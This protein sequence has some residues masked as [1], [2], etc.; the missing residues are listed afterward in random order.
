MFPR[1][2]RR[3]HLPGKT[4][5]TNS[6]KNYK[7]KFLEKL[8]VQIP[9]KTASTNSWKNYMYK[10]LEWNSPQVLLAFLFA[11]IKHKKIGYNL[12]I[13]ALKNVWCN[14]NTTHSRH[15]QYFYC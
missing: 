1:G 11:K 13:T 9:G 4:T 12:N 15:H 7:Y 10:F 2:I 5:S 14:I 6:W 8:Q 3:E